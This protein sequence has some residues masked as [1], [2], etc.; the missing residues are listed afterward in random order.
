MI[1]TD[2]PAAYISSQQSVPVKMGMATL[3][4]MLIAKSTAPYFALRSG[5]DYGARPP[6]TELRTLYLQSVDQSGERLI[7]RMQFDYIHAPLS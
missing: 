5:T 4:A 7:W 3:P 1:S 6:T 2:Y